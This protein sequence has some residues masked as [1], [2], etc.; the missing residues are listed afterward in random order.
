MSPSSP[1]RRGKHWSCVRQRTENQPGDRDVLDKHSAKILRR[2][3][4]FQLI[5][6]EITGST[7]AVRGRRRFFWGIRK[8]VPGG[9]VGF[10]RRGRD[11]L[12]LRQHGD[13]LLGSA[14][15][16]RPR[17]RAYAHRAGGEFR[18]RC[19]VGST[20]RTR[21]P[22][23]S[24]LVAEKEKLRSARSTGSC[25]PTGRG[26]LAVPG[27]HLRREDRLH[28]GDAIGLLGSLVVAHAYDARKP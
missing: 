21:G 13:G 9:I 26:V 28:G 1:A 17:G 5:A 18:S 2:H 20:L 19:R 11:R 24:V 7:R 8:A 25:G 16:G 27:G 3:E 15:A 23:L 4:L 6:H 22:G 14:D 10:G 12:G